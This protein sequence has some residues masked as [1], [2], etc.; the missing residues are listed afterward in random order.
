MKEYTYI[1]TCVSY[2]TDKELLGAKDNL[3]DAI[4]FAQDKKPTVGI[5]I[6]NGIDRLTTP[7][8]DLYITIIKTKI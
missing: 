1:I 7:K 2:E 8:L 5:Y 6:N 3:N 4:K